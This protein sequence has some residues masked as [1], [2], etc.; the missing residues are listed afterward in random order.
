M[1]TSP[2]HR[3]QLSRRGREAPASP[4]RR[5]VPLADQ[6][7][8]RGVRVYHLNIG[9]PDV[10]TPPVMLEALR[11]YKGP[12]LE[13][14]PSGGL[15]DFIAALAGYYA[16][17][18]VDVDE[19]HIMATTAGSEALTFSLAAVSDPGDEILIP[20]PLYANYRGFAAL[21]GLRVTPVPCSPDDGYA[22]P[23]PDVLDKAAGPR[24]RAMI[25]SNP[26]NPTGRITGR[27]EL[28]ALGDWIKSRDLFL[29]GDEVYREFCYGESPPPSV[30]QLPG[31][32]SHAIMVDSVSKRFSAC[33]A[34]IGSLVTRNEEILA[35]VLKFAQARLSPPTLGQLMATRAYRDIP[36]S[37]FKDVAQTYRRRRDLLCE[38]LSEMP[39]VLFKKPQGAF[40]L[41]ATLPVDDSD[42]FASWLL[43]D[44][45]HGG[46]TV[47]VAPGS[48]FYASPGS[49]RKEVRIAYVLDT[50]PLGRAMD[51]LSEGLKAYPGSTAA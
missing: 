15:P 18:G 26:G 39:G 1:T 50:E 23:G 2:D 34:R 19:R 13:Y 30:L 3:V 4:I 35:T 25:L 47:M 45:Q 31:L 21:L 36:P 29:I 11:D 44:F 8:R 42:A 5:L 51:A 12:V 41:M 38:R 20:E 43:T 28:K 6:A 32:E 49:G 16:R 40:Y 14:A 10:P 9:Q 48:G 46:E 37:Y 24:C 17:I 7:K 27:A 33:G 22:I